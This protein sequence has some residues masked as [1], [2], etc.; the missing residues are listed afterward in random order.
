MW[1]E[2]FYRLPIDAEYRADGD[3]WK[4]GRL[5]QGLLNQ[6]VRSEIKP[7]ANWISSSRWSSNDCSQIHQPAFNLPDP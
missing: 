2:V 7:A 1:R 3:V 4:I 5:L 6:S